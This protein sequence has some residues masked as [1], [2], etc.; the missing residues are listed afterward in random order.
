ML[1]TLAKCQYDASLRWMESLHPGTVG[2]LIILSASCPGVGPFCT[3]RIAHY[4]LKW[5]G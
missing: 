2:L 4:Q 1:V 5:A 3:H